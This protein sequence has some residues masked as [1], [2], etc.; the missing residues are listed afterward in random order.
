MTMANDDPLAW[1]TRFITDGT[2]A[3]DEKTRVMSKEQLEFYYAYTFLG[4]EEGLGIGMYKELVEIDQRL[5]MSYKGLR[6]DDVVHALTSLQEKEDENV[7]LQPL[8]QH[9][10]KKE[11]EA[12][13]AE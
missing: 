8:K 13:D 6:S 12:S 7:G 5:M 9:F 10:K 2:T 1:L 11:Q 3:P 4:S